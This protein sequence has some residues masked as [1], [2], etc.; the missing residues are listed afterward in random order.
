MSRAWRSL[1]L[2]VGGA[3]ALVVAASSYLFAEARGIHGW[4][5][6]SEALLALTAVAAAGSVAMLR[7]QRP[8]VAAEPP[9]EATI[10]GL[11][12]M[13]SHRAFQDRLEH[14]CD[15]AYR[16]GDSFALLLLDLDQFHLVNER[17]RHKTGDHVLT[18]L[19]GRLRGMI[20]EIDL[21]ARFGGDQF[22]LILP[23]TYQ[24]GGVDAAER[25][26]QSVAA[27]S[28]HTPE[29]TELRL[30]ASAGLAF[31]PDDGT[32]PAELVQAAQDAL[33]F[34]K[35]LGGNQIQLYPE[36]SSAGDNSGN[37]VK[38]TSAGY[39]NIVR[40]LAAAVEVRDRYTH[41]HSHFV[42][43]L[44][45][46]TARR[47]GFR[48]H[49]VARIKTGALLH[50]VGKIGVPDAVLTKQGG[51]T[52]SE[53]DSIRQHPVLGKKIIE[54]A[55]ELADVIPLVLYHQERFDG[56]GYPA[57]LSGDAIPIGARIIAAADA[58]YAIRSDRPYRSGRTHAEALQELRRCAETQF[59]PHVV[60]SLISV[61]EA[62]TDLTD[63]LLALEEPL[64]ISEPF[65]D[66][67]T[68]PHS[69]RPGWRPA[70]SG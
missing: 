59:D 26:R 64:A 15:R 1:P 53:W 10:D 51:L 27:W 23:H 2:L 37:V 58:Y 49:E 67:G 41:E 35:S 48:G 21:C 25:L 66:S 43:E 36:L 63:L 11:T 62:D 19:A 40:S 22:A 9:G 70:A 45:A 30:T 3:A 69:G 5:P 60:A 57:R 13:A 46:A 18:G 34:A 42:S 56:S 54:H 39:G 14:E 8:H 24:K 17:H 61:L 52:A 65:P 68:V 50:D 16:F 31:Y 33:A 4:P 12:R 29:S 32:T 28:F 55:P 7:S 47:M 20:R 6:G 38:L 44:A